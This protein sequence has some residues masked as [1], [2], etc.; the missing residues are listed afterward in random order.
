MEQELFKIGDIIK[1]HNIPCLYLDRRDH[2]F[3]VVF[4]YE[5]RIFYRYKKFFKFEWE[6]AVYSW[7][8]IKT[9]YNSWED[10]DIY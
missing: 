5:I 3:K 10:I 4:G 8:E 9:F 6:D 7:D 2:W 1:I